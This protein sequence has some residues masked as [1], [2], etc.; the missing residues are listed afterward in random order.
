MADMS[1]TH[2]HRH[3]NR[4]D[5]RRPTPPVV[6]FVSLGCAKNLVDSEKMLGLIAES[7]AIIS[8]E[9]S[10]HTVVVNT[11]GFLESARQEALEV[12]RGL[13]ERKRR[14]E[15]QR[16][17]VVG[18]LAQ[19]DGQGLR[20]AVPEID[21]LVGVHNRADVVRAVWPRRNRS[22][23]LFLGQ[24]HP[25]PWSDQGRLRL[26]PPHYAYVRISEGCDQKCTFCTIPAIRGP[27]HCKTP[28]TLATE[29]REMIADGARELILI[30]QD[31][32]SY[33]VD[34]GYEPGL[35][36]LLRHLDRACAGARWLRLMY[37]YPS[38]FTDAMIGALGECPRVVKYVDLPLQHINDRMLRAMGRRVTRRQTE[39]LLERLRQRIPGVTIRTTFIVG[40]PGETEAEFAELV[41]FV[42][43]FRFD[44][45]GAFRYSLEPDTPAG[46]MKEQL[47][48]AVKQERYE[49]LMQAQ[50]E[51]A[52]AAARQRVGAC[53]EVVVDE[54]TPDR[55]IAR[56]AGQA[57]EVDAVCIVSADGFAPGDYVPVRCVDTAGYDL[58]VEPVQVRLPVA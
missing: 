22:P 11:C 19:R 18:C 2:K 37:A 17:V 55:R 14:G 51:I 56:H 24:Y 40:F 21:A 35:A 44:A 34:T 27:L 4:A 58:V 48:E 29:C 39:E 8:N 31:P 54:H 5:G 15:L 3:A 53:F 36:G 50:Q 7:G 25:Q 43:D 10:A 57:P 33:G 30:G 45:V 42:R 47:D 1:K 12:I 32:T 16:I 49:R 9:S 23:E 52:F 38:V 41:S 26:T 13:A 20:D 6:G 28:D 46:R